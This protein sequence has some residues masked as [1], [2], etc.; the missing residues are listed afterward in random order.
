VA[1]L[2]IEQLDLVAGTITFYREKTDRTETHKLKRH[3]LQ[4]LET[5]L[6]EE[7]RTSGPLF[8]GNQGKALSRRAINARVQVLGQ[9]V[10][11]DDSK[12]LSPH[13]LRHFWAF[14]AL[15]KQT[16]F[17]RVKAAGGWRSDGMVLRYAARAGIANEGVIITEEE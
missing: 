15:R 14:D 4:S 10:G 3:T 13:D 12:T 16:P 7:K 8:L 6:A 1:G 9:R 5:Y 11:I 17:D 2:K